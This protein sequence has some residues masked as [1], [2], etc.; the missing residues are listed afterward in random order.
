MNR[1]NSRF[2][3]A[4]VLLH[5]VLMQLILYAMKPALSYALLDTAAL[6]L[7]LGIMVGAFALPALLLALPA[8]HAIDRA[9]YRVALVVGPL[10]I[11]AAALLAAFGRGTIVALLVAAVLLGLGH[12][13][14]AVGQQAM[15]ASNTSRSRIDSMF[16]FYTFAVA[17]GQTLGPLL[18]LLP[19]G[20]RTSANTFAVFLCCAATA[21][22]MLALPFVLR[23]VA[24]VSTNAPRGRLGRS[25]LDLLGTRGVPQA[26]VANTIAMSCVDIFLAYVP[27]LG[28]EH[29]VPTTTVSVI[30][31]V[32]SVFSMISRLFLGRMIHEF[33]R[34]AVNGFALAIAGLALGGFAFPLPTGWLIVLAAVFGFVVGTSTPITMTQVSER[35]PLNTQGLASSVRIASNRVGQTVLPPALGILATATGFPWVFGVSCLILLL[36]AWS[37]ASV[38][39]TANA[40]DP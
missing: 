25:T 10:I 29:H 12:L 1:A 16:G 34:R 18:L 8:G 5:A 9:G 31:V 24:T 35:A 17:L 23:R 14:S 7:F 21:V 3:V 40:E 13:V 15:I 30:L 38:R 37:G 36:G 26:L 28:S 22:A 27:A 19:G 20:T 6:P 4:I 32:R 33:G 2:T 11:V 39:D